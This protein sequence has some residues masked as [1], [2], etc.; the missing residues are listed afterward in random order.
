MKYHQNLIKNT[1]TQKGEKNSDIATYEPKIITKLTENLKGILEIV[2]YS[3]L[4]T[5]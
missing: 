3:E 4:I 2:R 5:D 1:D